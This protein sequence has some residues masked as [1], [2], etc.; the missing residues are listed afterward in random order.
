VEAQYIVSTAKLTDSASD[1]AR[2]E[3]LIEET[4]PQIPAECRDLNYLLFTPFRY[5]ATYPRG[6]RFRRAGVTPGVFYAAELAKTAATEIAFYRLLFFAESKSTPWPT[7]AG[8]YTAFSVGYQAGR[9]VDLTYPPFKAHVAIWTHPTNYEEC[10]ALAD[11]CRSQE[12]DIIK[13][14]SARS[15][16]PAINIAILRCRAFAESGIVERQTWRIQL[17]QTGARVI[18]EFPRIV[19]DFGPAA[20]AS[21]P[22]IAKMTWER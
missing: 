10:Q 21:D 8:E 7:N 4:K 22:R 6:S 18:C 14:Q 2:L 13:Y 9:S 17:S 20:F 15:P 3:Q 12:I 11:A 1:Q 16:E 5:G 19:L